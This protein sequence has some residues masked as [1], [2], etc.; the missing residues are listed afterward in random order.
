MSC[1]QQLLVAVERLAVGGIDRRRSMPTS[2]T[3]RPASHAIVSGANAE[4][5]ADHAVG[6]VG[7]GAHQHARRQV[8]GRMRQVLGVDRAALVDRV[9][10]AAAA[11]ERIE[12]DGADRRPRRAP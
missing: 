1:A 2:L 4:N 6:A 10:H 5:A 8:V 12:I 3:P 11:E 7:A 9:N